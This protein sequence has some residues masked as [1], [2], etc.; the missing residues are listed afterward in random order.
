MAASALAYADGIDISHWQGTV[1]W[2]KVKDDGMGFAFMKATEGT[3]TPTRA[4][5]PTGRAPSPGDLPRRVPLRAALR[6]RLGGRAGTVLRLQGRPVDDKGDLPPVLDL[7][8]TGGLG[9]PRCST[10]VTTWLTTTES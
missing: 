5:G 3:T 10:W 9:P 8:A 6:L 7:E 2:S 1:S 4:C